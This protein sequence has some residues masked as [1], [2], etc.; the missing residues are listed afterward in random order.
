MGMISEFAIEATV[1]SIVTEIEKG[2]EENKDK[3][4][5]LPV[6]KRMGRFALNEFEWHTPP[7]AKRYEQLFK[8]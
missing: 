2:L 1:R 7:W 8:E 5:V 3:P 6:L 4:E